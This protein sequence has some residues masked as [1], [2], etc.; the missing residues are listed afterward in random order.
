MKPKPCGSCR[1]PVLFVRKAEKPQPGRSEWV[2]LDVEQLN[3]NRQHDGRRLRLVDGSR[4]YTL[5]DA[6]EHVELQGAVLLR[7]GDATRV[8]DMAWHRTHN[9]PNRR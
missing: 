8:E 2:V 9:C 5:R 4:A 3:P 6:H 7:P 1:A